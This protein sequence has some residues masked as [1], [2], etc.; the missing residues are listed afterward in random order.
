M[1]AGVSTPESRA[2]LRAEKARLDEHIADLQ[3]TRDRLE[4]VIE[5]SQEPN[6]HCLLVVGREQTLTTR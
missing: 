4:A 2:R 5:L 6:A 3:R 1:D